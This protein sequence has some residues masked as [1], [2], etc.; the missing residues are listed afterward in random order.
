MNKIEYLTI[1]IENPFEMLGLIV[2]LDSKGFMCPNFG[3]TKG[4][5]HLCKL[6]RWLFINLDEKI[7]MIGDGDVKTIK[8]T[9][10]STH[11]IFNNI[12]EL[13]DYLKDE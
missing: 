3:N 11:I 8:D 9:N 4:L 1:R 13:I 6:N 5:V 7:I 10:F 2:F 12:N